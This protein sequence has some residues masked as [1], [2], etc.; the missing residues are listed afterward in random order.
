MG[1]EGLGS[2]LVGLVEGPGLWVFEGSVLCSLL[3]S[4]A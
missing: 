4:H 3:R 2:R 1:F